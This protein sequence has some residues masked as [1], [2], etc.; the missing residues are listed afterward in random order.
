ME[1][2]NVGDSRWTPLLKTEQ[3]DACEVESES[4]CVD[5]LGRSAGYHP[6]KGGWK[7]A[8]CII[9]AVAL[10]GAGFYG[11][12][13]TLVLYLV[14][15][16]GKSNAAAATI[17][18]NFTGTAMLCSFVGGL[19]SDVYLGRWRTTVIFQGL[20]ALCL[21]LAS[22]MVMVISKGPAS[23][24]E[25]NLFCTTLY[26]LAISTG[27]VLPNVLALGADQL[28]LAEEKQRYFKLCMIMTTAAQFLALMALIYLDGTGMW[29]WGFLVCTIASA[30]CLAMLVIPLNRLCQFKAAG[31]PF[32]R[33]LQVLVAACRNYSLSL[34]E[35]LSLLFETEGKLSAIP[36]CPK[37]QH[38]T[39]LRFLDKAAVVVNPSDVPTTNPWHLCTVSQVEELKSFLHAMPVGIAIILVAT[40]NAQGSTLFEE[41]A[42]EM[43]REVTSWLT[44]SSASLNLISMAGSIVGGIVITVSGPKVWC[45]RSGL[46]V[47]SLQL[48]G[49]ALVLSGVA[50]LIAALVESYRL[51][52]AQKG[53]LI[54]VMWLVPQAFLVGA[55]SNLATSGGADFLYS[56]AAAGMRSVGT[57]FL[58]IFMGAGNYFSAIL[59]ALVTAISTRG[60]RSGWIASNLNDGHVDY[61]YWLLLL[62]LAL[63][64]GMHIAYSRS[65]QS[66]TT[67]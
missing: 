29:G 60:G 24:L 5:R 51:S 65:L 11:V 54:S 58:F 12:I 66:K 23:T 47:T 67:S 36:G 9:G 45:G 55:G 37:L 39:S 7:C 32:L 46:R 59:V 28:S 30:A 53:S 8:I 61:F 64:L 41:Q 17:V 48:L 26:L 3:E 40:A 18:C 56:Q 38:T 52:E 42:N 1:A 33:N 15:V 19:L 14:Q 16:C 20:S 25:S 21:A 50:V 2:R 34:P 35:D 62:C 44:L 13:Y 63:A 4:V 31:N 27:Q 49:A 10:G 22:M 6:E 43:N 57:S